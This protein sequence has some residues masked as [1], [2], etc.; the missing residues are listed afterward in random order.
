VRS[1]FA[2]IPELVVTTGPDELI[3]LGGVTKRITI[4]SRPPRTDDGVPRVDAQPAPGTVGVVV[5]KLLTAQERTSLEAAGLS[6]CDARGSLHV[7]WPGLYVH[8]DRGPR[9]SAKVNR[10]SSAGVG[11][12]SIRAIQTMLAQPD[13]PWSTARLAKVAAV[14]TGQA[15]NI[16][17]TLEGNRLLRSEGSGPK[18]RRYL[19]DADEVMQWLAGIERARRRPESASSYL[20]ART[21][22]DLIERF[23]KRATEHKLRYAITAASG[24]MALGHPV[25]TN[26]VLL[27]IRVS[28][29]DAAHALDILGL[30][31]LDA[32]D[33]GRGAN[34]E[35]WTDTGELG[36]F[37]PEIASVGSS[38]IS[39]APRIR[40]WLD[41]VRQGGRVADA[42]DLFKEQALD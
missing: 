15:H 17:K 31:H 41:M 20:Y 3:E 11:A 23:A 9:T 5:G 16:M 2:S 25:I 1:A 21:F 28:P 29:I 18:Q 6:W 33:A 24:A 8:V 7:T 13:A 32:E 19:R 26:P 27:Q 42:A 38:E 36:T 37:R 30:E 35:L 10:S 14:S 4:M 34:L 40:V 22:E 39:V 12:T